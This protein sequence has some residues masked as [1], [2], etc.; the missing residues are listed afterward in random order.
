MDGKYA[1][2]VK[3]RFVWWAMYKSGKFS[4]NWKPGRS[5]CRG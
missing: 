4:R 1:E 2:C 5:V 3:G